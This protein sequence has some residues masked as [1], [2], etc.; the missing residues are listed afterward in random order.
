[1]ALCTQQSSRLQ[2]PSYT[3]MNISKASA[4]SCH[5]ANILGRL[6]SLKIRSQFLAAPAD[7]R[8]TLCKATNLRCWAAW[9]TVSHH[10]LQCTA[11][12]PSH[13]VTCRPGC[14]CRLSEHLL[15]LQ[16]A[17]E[18][19]KTSTTKAKEVKAAEVTPKPKTVQESGE[20]G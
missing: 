2:T 16:A 10:T 15:V 11:S 9:P 18:R 13:L 14:P 6:Q 4:S 17:L 5:Q 3:A 20:L 1:M 8:C 7:S 19:G 12:I